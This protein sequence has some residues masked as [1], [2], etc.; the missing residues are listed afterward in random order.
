[1]LTE[2]MKPTHTAM[3]NNKRFLQVQE[4]GIAYD[5][6]ESQTWRGTKTQEKRLDSLIGSAANR[7][8]EELAVE[9]RSR[10][11][12]EKRRMHMSFILIILCA[13]I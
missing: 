4:L 5:N 8:D 7:E 3:R 13:F 1:M 9:G 6:G 10:L 11:E 12:A 2:Q